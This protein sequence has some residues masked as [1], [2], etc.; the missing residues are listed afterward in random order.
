MPKKRGNK[1]KKEQKDTKNFRAAP[2]NPFDWRR[3]DFRSHH[4]T[5]GWGMWYNKI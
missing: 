2:G 1:S 5:G 3:R 4:F